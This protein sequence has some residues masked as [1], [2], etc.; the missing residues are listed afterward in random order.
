MSK[1]FSLS[2]YFISFTPLWISV[3]F[4]D[5][6]SIFTSK[7]SLYTEYISLFCIVVGVAIS[8]LCIRSNL[9]KHTLEGT[10]LVTL[11]KSVKQ[12]TITS[13]FL[14]SYILPLFAF[15]F[16]LWDNVILFLIFFTTFGYLCIKHN[17][18]S[19]NIVLEILNYN[20]YFCNV[21]NTD[22]TNLDITIISRDELSLC[23]GEKISIKALNN[24][25]NLHVNN[26]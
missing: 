20:I 24:D 22:K 7:V 1:I 26:N 4:I 21:E 6:K 9:K 3:I 18:F 13:E 23:K 25:F 17:Y 19:A 5:L 12:K 2:L 14:L 16:T 10:S 15:D 11:Q 8:L